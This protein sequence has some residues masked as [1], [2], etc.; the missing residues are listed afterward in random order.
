MDI[1]EKEKSSKRSAGRLISKMC[2]NYPTKNGEISPF[3]WSRRTQCHWANCWQSF[4][5]CGKG[6][7]VGVFLGV[8][9]F[10]VRIVFADKLNLAI[11]FFNL[12]A[13][14]YFKKLKIFFKPPPALFFEEPCLLAPV[15]VTQQEISQKKTLWRE[16][17]FFCLNPFLRNKIDWFQG[18]NREHNGMCLFLE[19]MTFDEA[20]STDSSAMGFWMDA[21]SDGRTQF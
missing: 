11:S 8:C 17:A 18:K 7:E 3:V 12:S 2:G 16:V 10:V 9:L 1:S 5:I 4:W 21:R 6:A 14:Q 13:L 19:P 20:K 15:G